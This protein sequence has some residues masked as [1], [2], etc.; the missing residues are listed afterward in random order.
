MG[1]KSEIVIRRAIPTDAHSIYS[2]YKRVTTEFPAA[3]ARG[4]DEIQ[5]DYVEQFMDASH[6][7]GV[8]LVAEQDN[9]VVGELHTYRSDLKVFSHVFCNLTIAISPSFHSRGIG[10]RL[11]TSLLNIVTY[12]YPEIRRIE[13]VVRESNRRA[14]KLYESVGFSVEG[15][16]IGR[17]CTP[18]GSFEAD[19]PMAWL[20]GNHIL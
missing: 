1:S 6:E 10:R 2:L 20:R 8:E 17:I 9:V 18:D 13:L 3:L 12:E 7:H 16:M 11:F 14:I 4:C 5:M 19:V 15:Q